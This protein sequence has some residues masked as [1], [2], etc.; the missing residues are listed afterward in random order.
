MQR[1]RRGL[2][3]TVAL[4]S[5]TQLIHIQLH[6]T[7]RTLRHRLPIAHIRRQLEVNSSKSRAHAGVDLDG[8]GDLSDDVVHCAR[9]DRAGG[10]SVAVHGI[11]APDDCPQ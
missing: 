4:E 5:L 1:E 10:F 7:P 11:A 6:T 9:L 2:T 8:G 3:I